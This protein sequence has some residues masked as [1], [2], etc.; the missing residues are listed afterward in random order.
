MKRLL[1]ITT[2]SFFIT[3]AFNLF[4]FEKISTQD[5]FYSYL[6]NDSELKNL[7][8]EAEKAQLALKSSKI[9]NGFCVN[10]TSGSVILKTTGQNSTLSVKSAGVSG[11]IPQ[12]SNLTISATSNYTLDEQNPSDSSQFSEL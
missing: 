7:T 10:L 11:Q 2:I 8:I 1:L 6:K 9:E 5:L 12:A 4:G 3:G